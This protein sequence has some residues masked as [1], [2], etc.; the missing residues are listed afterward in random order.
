MRAYLGGDFEVIQRTFLRS[1]DFLNVLRLNKPRE[2][3][4]WL[5]PWDRGRALLLLEFARASINV[6]PHY[7]PSIV[8]AGRRYVATAP[9]ADGGSDGAADFVQTWHRAAAGVLQGGSDPVHVEEHVADLRSATGGPGAPLDPRLELAH[10]VAQER[11]CWAKRPSLDRPAVPVDTLLDAAGIRI[12]DDPG[13]LLRFG[14][15]AT[16]DKHRAC[17]RE[18]LARFE[19]AAAV[20][21]IAAE[22]R[23]RGGWVLVQDGRAAEAVAWL[24]AA[25]PRDDREL[26]YW[27]ALF[28]GRALDIV[29]RFQDA[30][31]AYRAA[32]ALYP[33]AQ[34]AGAGLSIAL[35]HLDRTKDADEI[36][37]AVRAAGAQTPDP[38]LYYPLGDERFVGRRLD[39]LR[40]SVK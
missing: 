34:S 40:A 19:V 15:E 17:L 30:V 2:L 7:A 38:W 5:G 18:A 11:R 36:A 22:A 21:G 28:R 24:D 4:R 3:E 25:S 35:M 29:G 10:A 23:V 39:A 27:H 16:I 8:R 13:G 14:R 20:E 9:G 26:E 12:P 1:T 6:A 33:L 31:I 37:R 32:L